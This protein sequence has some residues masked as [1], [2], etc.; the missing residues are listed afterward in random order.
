MY[1]NS[2][3][4]LNINVY[5]AFLWG[6]EIIG[7]DYVGSWIKSKKN[8]LYVVSVLALSS[9][10]PEGVITSRKVDSPAPA[11]V[12]CANIEATEQHLLIFRPSEVPID[13]LVVLSKGQNLS[14]ALGDMLGRRCSDGN[15]DSCDAQAGRQFRFS[16][17]PDHNIL[18]VDFN[19]IAVEIS[20]EE[21]CVIDGSAGRECFGDIIYISTSHFDSLSQGES[22]DQVKDFIVEVFRSGIENLELPDERLDPEFWPLP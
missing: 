10:N 21:A 2:T 17:P 4:E 12:G 9:C 15:L 8:L 19:N 5:P 16:V 14:C 11:V 7:E 22:L 18:D 20:E 3:Y 13:Y 1:V 6:I